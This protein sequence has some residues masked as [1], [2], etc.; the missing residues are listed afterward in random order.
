MTDGS[1]RRMPP[2]LQAMAR[3][4]VT[5][6][7]SECTALAADRELQETWQRLVAAWAASANSA[8]AWLPA[9]PDGPPGRPGAPQSPG[10]PTASAA[11][12]PRDAEIERLGRRVAELERRLTELESGRR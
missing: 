11:P 1:G 7:Q 5:L 4:W 9:G 2:D 8:A 6:V 3:D 10:A 12:D